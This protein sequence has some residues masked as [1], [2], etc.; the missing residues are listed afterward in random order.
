VLLIWC[1]SEEKRKRSV[2]A[3]FRHRHIVTGQEGRASRRWRLRESRSDQGEPRGASDD[4]AEGQ[5]AAHA[6]A[7]FHGNPDHSTPFQQTNR[8][9]EL[10]LPGHEFGRAPSILTVLGAKLAGVVLPL[11]V[12]K[13]FAT[14]VGQ[15]TDRGA[16]RRERQ[17]RR[18]N[19]D[20]RPKKRGLDRER[21]VARGL[22]HGVLDVLVTRLPG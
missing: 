18:S 21:L 5:E 4:V 2:S 1:R 11:Q 17:P 22:L 13:E 3:G 7:Q 16:A 14:E 15:T 10:V 12:V 19:R 20:A 8:T 9:V 6:C